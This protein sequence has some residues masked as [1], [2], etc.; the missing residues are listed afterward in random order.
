M[1]LL[2]YLSRA[3]WHFVWKIKQTFNT[4][5]SLTAAQSSSVLMLISLFEYGK[6]VFSTANRLRWHLYFPFSFL[7]S[8]LHYMPARRLEPLNTNV[9]CVFFFAWYSRLQLVPFMPLK[10][11][12]HCQGHYYLHLVR[13]TDDVWRSDSDTRCFK[14][15][16]LWCYL[17]ERKNYRIVIPYN[18]LLT[19]INTTVTRRNELLPPADNAFF[20]CF[21]GIRFNLI[22]S[23]NVPTLADLFIL[24]EHSQ[25]LLLKV[26]LPSTF[27]NEFLQP[28]TPGVGGGTPKWNRRGCSSKMLN[29]TPKRDH[30]G[31]AQAFCD[32]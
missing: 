28:A 6:V 16:R 4:W 15:H 13:V 24:R 9:D 30:L 1:K 18:A 17:V 26:N 25:S 31:V 7:L 20:N 12:I 21:R 8:L 29:L 19:C 32:P 14:N 5:S 27:R 10:S 3:A 22:N 23:E 11:R 2:Q